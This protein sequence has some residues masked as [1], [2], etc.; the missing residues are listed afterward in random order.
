MVENKYK[1]GHP[2]F[3]EEAKRLGLT[4]YEYRCKLVQERVLANPYKI[5]KQKGDNLLIKKGFNSY[6]E[7]QNELA[8]N[9]GFKN[10]TEYYN[11]LAKKNGFKIYEE[12]L[13]KN[14]GLNNCKE[15]RDVLAKEKGF[16]NYAER[17]NES[18]WNKGISSPMSENENCPQYLG[19]HIAEMKIAKIILSTIFGYVEEMRYGNPKFDFICT[20]PKLEFIN[21]NP[22]FKLIEDKEYKVDIKSSRLNSHSRQSWLFYTNYNNVA[23]YFLL[24]GFDDEFDDDDKLCPMHIWLFKRDEIIRRKEFYRRKGFGITNKTYYLSELNIY[25]LKDELELLKESIN[26]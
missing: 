23:D 1:V 10:R 7:Y 16:K 6:T 22:T 2:E 26:I 12:Y 20:S 19:I 17:Q 4:P 14:R 18:N 15:Y 25:E 9:R 11:D 5:D 21:K 13:A 8:K 3:I 24:I